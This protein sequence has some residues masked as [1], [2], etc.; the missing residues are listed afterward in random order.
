MLLDT[1]H[2]VTSPKTHIANL[3]RVS[4]QVKTQRLTCG[5]MRYTEVKILRIYGSR[6][7][8]LNFIRCLSFKTV[9]INNYPMC[10]YH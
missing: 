3:S 6:L 8:T 9:I 5:K 10:L 2:V 7:K 4:I 1:L